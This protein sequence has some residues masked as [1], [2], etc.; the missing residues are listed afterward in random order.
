MKADDLLDQLAEKAR[1]GIADRN[2]DLGAEELERL[3]LQIATA[4][5]RFLMVK[6][7]TT[8]VIA[9]DFDDA[10][11]FEGDTGPYLQYSL[12][13]EHNIRRRLDEAG[14]ASA[15][16]PET[17]AALPADIWTD[18]L[19]DLVLTVGQTAEIAERAATTLELSLL[20]RH[21]IDMARQFHA[22][23]HRHP[24]LQEEDE[25]LRTVC[26]AANQIFHK[27]LTQVL[28]ILGIPVPARM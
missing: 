26:L 28:Q 2:R 6:A 20:A 21:A 16:T 24:I 19:W 13:R 18:D 9:F 22:I 15:V 10:L 1:S 11:N 4:A 3:S 5:M 17:I 12:V 25:D 8:R 14:I 27:G 23:Y 7:T